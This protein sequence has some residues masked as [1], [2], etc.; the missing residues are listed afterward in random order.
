[1][2]FVCRVAFHSGAVGGNLPRVCIFR[3]TAAFPAPPGARQRCSAGLRG[4][5]WCR[6]KGAA[7]A[8]CW[9]RSLVQN[10]GAAALPKTG[11]WWPSSVWGSAPWRFIKGK[12]L[13]CEWAVYE[14][15]SFLWSTICLPQP[16]LSAA[17]CLLRETGIFT[18]PPPELVS[19][20]VAQMFLVSFSELI[21]LWSSQQEC[22]KSLW[23]LL[24]VKIGNSHFRGKGALDRH[25]KWCL[26]E[27]CC[28]RNACNSCLGGCLRFA[29][30]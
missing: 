8:R 17:G 30:L 19:L 5:A 18:S 23:V 20:H 12:L 4:A 10:Q 6:G 2:L 1:M 15:P 11:W 24:E 29:G 21:Q 3:L 26:L 7:G 14:A 13:A 9:Q 27:P 22:G 16:L 25:W 28:C